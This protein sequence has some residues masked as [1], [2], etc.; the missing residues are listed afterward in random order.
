MSGYAFA[1]VACALVAVII[2]SLLRTRKIREKYAGIWIVVAL[3]N[4]VLAVFPGLAARVADLVGVTTPVNLLFAS[5]FIVLLV[6]CVHLSTEL[7][8]IEDQA[9]TV[10]EE[11]ALLRL[12]IE[13]ALGQSRTGTPPDVTA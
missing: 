9:R 2:F 13:D 12:D 1:V 4:I 3:A 8:R 5:A 6:V 10:A 7:S 11:V